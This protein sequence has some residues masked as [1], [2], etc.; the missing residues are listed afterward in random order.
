MIVGDENADPLDGDATFD[1]MD[2]LLSN[3]LV[4]TSVTPTSAGALEQVPPGFSAPETKT[5][6]FNLRANYALPAKNKNWRPI[7]FGC[8]LGFSHRLDDCRACRTRCSAGRRLATP[9]CQSTPYGNRPGARSQDE[10][11]STR[12]RGRSTRRV[13]RS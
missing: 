8:L 10:V 2:L 5:A 11:L 6:S 13:N 4:D 1:P 12:R 3:A 7:N 9:D